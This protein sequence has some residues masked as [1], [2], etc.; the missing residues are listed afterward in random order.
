M[1]KGEKKDKPRNRP[2]TIENK[3]MV[4]RGKVGEGVGEIDDGD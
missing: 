2:L 1:S 4:T 3:L